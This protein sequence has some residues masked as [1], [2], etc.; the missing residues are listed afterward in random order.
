MRGVA[1][2]YRRLAPRMNFVVHK[3]ECAFV[4][5]IERGA[6]GSVRFI[7]DDEIEIGKLVALLSRADCVDRVI[8]AEHDRHARAVVPLGD[9]F[10]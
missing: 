7:A 10:G 4:F 6:R 8:G 1:V 5:I 3:N 2:I 9:R